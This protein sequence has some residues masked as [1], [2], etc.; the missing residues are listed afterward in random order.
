MTSP[1]LAPDYDVAIVG[2][3]PV[4]QLMAALLGQMRYRVVVF[5]RWPTLYPL[6]RACVIDDEGMR[7]LQQVGVAA[8]FLPLVVPTSGQYIWLNAHNEVLYHFKHDPNGIS[9]WPARSLMYQPDLEGLLHERVLQLDS[10]EL[11][12]GWQAIAYRDHG[13]YGELTVRAGES[14]NDSTGSRPDRKRRVTARF[15]IGADGAHSFVRQA[16][17]IDWIDLGFKADWLVVDFRPHDP[18]KPLDMP[19]AAQLCDPARPITLMR[20]M[21]RR[22]VRWEMM[23]LPSDNPDEMTQ[24]QR[25]WPLISR[26]VSP[27]DGVLERAALY[28]FRSGV[29]RKWRAGSA[30][31]VGDA[32]HLMPPF[33]GQ[34]LCSG[35]RDALALSWRLDLILRNIVDATLLRSYEEERQ[36]HVRAVIDRAVALGQVV[37]IT[38][39][40]LAARRD[41]RIRAGIAPPLPQFPTMTSGLFY[42]GVADGQ[43]AGAVGTV[44]LQAP[45]SGS[46]GSGLFDDIVGH[47][48]VVLAASED[49]R[50][51]LSNEHLAFL[52]RINTRF[53]QFG[54]GADALT[55]P[56][57]RYRSCFERL[58]ACALII[59]PDFHVFAVLLSMAELPQIVEFLQRKLLAEQAIS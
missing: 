21:G 33:L 7:I 5:E 10:V 41:A 46:S 40:V 55:D 16:A 27:Q 19:E 17:G 57:G 30:V 2:Y 43:A 54:S 23:L 44:S 52:T 20:H 53:A 14:G 28:T 49:P 35:L 56:G 50:K 6:P 39:E 51:V 25:V 11:N 32:A 1:P 36:S 58:G 9:G 13:R 37:C 3:G 4:G 59:R 34:G 8:K 47:G 48:W 24:P 45:V 29:A 26:W 18:D 12:R 31:L 38:D 22:H 15:V 42:H